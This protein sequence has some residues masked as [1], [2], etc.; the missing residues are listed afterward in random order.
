M[1]VET[2]KEKEINKTIQSLK[3]E[4]ET[5]RSRKTISCPQCNKRTALKNATIIIDYWYQ[6]PYG[7]TEGDNWLFN[8][9]QYFCSCCQEK[10]RAYIGTFD[11]VN[12]NK[13]E[14]KP[15]ALKLPRVQLFDFIKHHLQYFGETL[16]SYDDGDLSIEQ[17]REKNKKFSEQY[18]V[19]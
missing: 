12:W 13:S 17:L 3:Q 18:D 19:Y 4:R 1:K 9:Y 11:L 14:L 16:M 2:P 5:I 8:E 6:Q 15:E 10:T 7:C